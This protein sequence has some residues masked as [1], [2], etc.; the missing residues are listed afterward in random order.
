[1]SIDVCKRVRA[2]RGL[3]EVALSGGL[4]QNQILFNL[5]REGLEQEEFIVY[6]HQRVPTNDGG[7][8]LGQAVIANHAHALENTVTVV[9]GASR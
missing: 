6:V 1:M 3:N 4:W 8:A 5:V 9:G 2:K 7:L